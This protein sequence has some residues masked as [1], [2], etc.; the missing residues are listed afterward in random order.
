LH[1]ISD[2][3]SV[4]VVL[5]ET[6]VSPTELYESLGGLATSITIGRPSLEDVFI[7]IAGKS[8]G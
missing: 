7:R 1:G 8:F 4:R 3:G 2:H 5:Q 6:A